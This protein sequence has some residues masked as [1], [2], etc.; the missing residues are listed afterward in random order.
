MEPNE[1]WLDHRP[2][3]SLDPDA[4]FQPRMQRAKSITKLV[5]H[6]DV[7]DKK[8]NKYVLTTQEQ[9]TTSNQFSN[10]TFWIVI[11]DSGWT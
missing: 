5:D 7:T 11:F 3:K 1:R 6:K 2:M 4:V 10:T 8:I 9:V